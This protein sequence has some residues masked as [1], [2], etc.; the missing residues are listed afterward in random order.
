MSIDATRYGRYATGD[1]LEHQKRYATQVRESDRVIIDIVRDIVE[2]GPRG[3]A[4]SPLDAGCSTGNLLRHLRRLVPALA[5]HG[6]DA[7]PLIIEQERTDP[8]LPE[9]RAGDIS[10]NLVA[11]AAD[12]R[13]IFHAATVRPWCHLI[14]EK[15]A[16]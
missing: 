1:Y 5:L 6:G 2:E 14:A 8:D 9:P 16:R 11:S 4:P 15:T 7:Y 13:F 10:S 12:D 3:S